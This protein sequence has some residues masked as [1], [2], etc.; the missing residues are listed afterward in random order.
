MDYTVYSYLGY[1]DELCY[2][3]G[4]QSCAALVQYLPYHP[5]TGLGEG[6]RE[7]EGG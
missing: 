1:L 3:L 5:I 7:G 6:G 4:S 2:D